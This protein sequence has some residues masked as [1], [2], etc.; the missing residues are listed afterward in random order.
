M[1]R[2][3]SALLIFALA[4]GCV[5]H[6]DPHAARPPQA[7]TAG[8]KDETPKIAGLPAPVA[9]A[10]AVGIGIGLGALLLAGM[11]AVGLASVMSSNG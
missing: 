7:E 11:T 4:A 2:S 9:V 10:G 8:A 3:L 1:R 6:E 5:A